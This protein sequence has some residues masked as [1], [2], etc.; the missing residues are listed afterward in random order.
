MRGIRRSGVL[1]ASR[2]RQQVRRRLGTMRSKWALIG[3]NI[4]LLCSFAIASELPKTSKPSPGDVTMNRVAQIKVGS[5]TEA[6]VKEL[7]G[8]PL[9]TTSYGDCNV[10]DYQNIWEYQGHDAS[11]RVKI[12]IQFD[13]AG[14]ARIVT[15]TPSKGPVVVLAATPPPK[16]AHQH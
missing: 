16:A 14:I 11:G 2:N 13:E 1:P 3:L 6:R 8:N 7:L 10:V 15:K 4:M 5:S 12:S 9:R